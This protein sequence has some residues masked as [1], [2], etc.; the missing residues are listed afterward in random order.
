MVEPSSILTPL[1]RDFLNAFFA[2]PA[3]QKFF[4]TGGTALAAFHLYHRYSE[5][6][7]LFTLDWDALEAMEREMPI[8]ASEIN[9]EWSL[10]VKATDF[11]AILLNRPPEPTLKIDLVR[12]A[13]AQFGEYQ[14]FGNIVVDSMLNIAVNKVTA[15]FGRTA[16]K[17]FVDLY[18]LLQRGFDLDELMRMAKAKDLGFSEFYFAGSL[19]QIRRVQDLPRMI[20]PV[21]LEELVTFFQPL[22]EQIMLKLK[23][24]V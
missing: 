20:Q 2:R 10:K 8:V 19:G 15:V 9:C 7:D 3:A 17:D 21:T 12:D 22:A 4:L 14:R 23:P 5:D 1:Q 18:F 6:L 11:R 13:G 24:R 16:A